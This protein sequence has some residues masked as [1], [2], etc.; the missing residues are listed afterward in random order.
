MPYQYLT[1]SDLF[2]EESRP[3]APPSSVLASSSLS[4]A[5]QLFTHQPAYHHHKMAMAPED[6]R[7][8]ARQSSLSSSGRRLHHAQNNISAHD[9]YGAS[10]SSTSSSL[11][12]LD[13]L[14]VWKRRSFKHESHS[15]DSALSTPTSS[16]RSS[17]SSQFGHLHPASAA[18][19]AN[20]SPSISRQVTK[21]SSDYDA[22]VQKTVRAEQDEE[23][24]RQRDLEAYFLTASQTGLTL[25]RM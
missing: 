15:T 20:T 6:A 11:L 16:R 14:K 24:Q 13:F 18:S 2:E 21:V 25:R 8:V 7:R 17:F 3:S 1:F 5:L 22:F 19:S 23:R 9:S 4:P 10:S 12:H